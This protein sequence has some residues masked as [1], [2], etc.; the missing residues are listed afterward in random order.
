MFQVW[1]GRV[2][3]QLRASQRFAAA[4]AN[5][6]RSVSFSEIESECESDYARVTAR[7]AARL[8]AWDG[9]GVPPMDR[10]YPLSLIRP[11]SKICMT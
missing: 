3:P 8:I 1:T 2:A 7:G 10:A 6:N 11:P 4:I 9:R 5:L